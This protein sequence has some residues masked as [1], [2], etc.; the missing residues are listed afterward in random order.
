MLATGSTDGTIRLFDLA[1]QRP[2][3]C[4]AARPSPNRPI[5]PV[6]TPDGAYL[7]AITDA[8]RALPLGHPPVLMGAARLR[9]RRP[10]AHPDRVER[11]A[12]RARLRARL[13]ARARTGRLATSPST[14]RSCG[15]PPR[16]HD[17]HDEAP[18]PPTTSPATS[19][20]QLAAA[21]PTSAP[22]REQPLTPAHPVEALSRCGSSRALPQHEL[23]SER[24]TTRSAGETPASWQRSSPGAPLGAPAR[25]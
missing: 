3:R 13:L 25:C 20:S 18:R 6:F 24:T 4:A 7:F 19:R 22:G 17:A 9:D 21:L 11:R 8:G 1:T 10:P 5:A 12:A 2:R 23:L 15:R 14:S 16:R